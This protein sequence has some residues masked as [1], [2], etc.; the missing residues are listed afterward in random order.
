MKKT[1]TVLALII[2]LSASAQNDSNNKPKPIPPPTLSDSTD[3]ISV[4]DIN[5]WLETIQDKVSFKQYQD[6]MAL[7]NNLVDAAR[8]D[9][10][11]QE[12]KKKK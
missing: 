9:W 8:K 12:A 2:S 10:M 4:Q 5:K 7:I 11:E 1:I 3:F 6:F